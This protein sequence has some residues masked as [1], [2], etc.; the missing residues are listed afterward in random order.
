MDPAERA[1][2]ESTCAFIH[3]LVQKYGPVG[4]FRIFGTENRPIEPDT[5]STV[6]GNS[7]NL[8]SSVQLFFIPLCLFFRFHSTAKVRYWI[9]DTGY[10]ILDT[11]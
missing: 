7:V 3:S 4:V 1:A 11:R 10:S 2:A 9:L 6:V 5:V 8:P